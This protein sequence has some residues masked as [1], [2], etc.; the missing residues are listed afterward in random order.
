MNYSIALP[1]KSEL[2]AAAAYAALALDGIS[3]RFNRKCAEID[4]WLY[5]E[6]DYNQR[7]R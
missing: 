2:S 1:T 7:D 4:L 6:H 5:L 3:L